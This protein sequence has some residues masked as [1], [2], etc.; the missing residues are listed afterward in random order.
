MTFIKDMYRDEI[1][2]GWLVKSSVKKAWNKMLE[3]WQEVD[4]ICK[5]YDIKYWAYGGTLLGAARHGG[6]IP[7]D[8]D[9]DI[10]LMRPEYNILCD[11]VE[12]ELI[13]EDS[14]FE[15]GRRDFNNYRIALSSTTMILKEDLYERVPDAPYGMMIDIFPLD[16]APDNTLEGN[17]SA[18]KLWE[19][20]STINDS[21]YYALKEKVKNGQ[22]SYNDWETIEY[23][24]ALPK[25]GQQE[26]YN[27]YAALLFDKSGS[28][29]WIDHVNRSY[30]SL[31][32]YPFLQ[33][34]W[35]RETIYLPFE[36]VK[37]PCPVDY[38]KELVTYYNDWHKFVCDRQFHMGD[39]YS[40]DIPYEEFFERVNPE[41]MFPPEE[42]VDANSLNKEKAS[43]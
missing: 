13:Q 35:F 17:L 18:L 31:Q 32:E 42:E 36:S 1:R 8:T 25:N 27:Q 29:I 30:S 9:F 38:E 2:D 14:A 41:L 21:N 19:L 12:R 5:K 40:P 34:E 24:R 37:L 15:V 33:K 10:C 6:F 7:W 39:V 28:T 22:K 3:I 26:F 11:A 20:L 16:I 4:R 43:T 23:F